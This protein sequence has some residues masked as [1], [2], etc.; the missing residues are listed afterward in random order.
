MLSKIISQIGKPCYTDKITADLEQGEGEGRLSYAR[1]LVEVNAHDKLKDQ[2]ILRG[3]DGSETIQK[4]WYEWRPWQCLKCKS[5]GHKEAEC[6][7]SSQK[8]VVRK[9]LP[10]S[11]PSHVN[12]SDHSKAA[13]HPNQTSNAESSKNDGQMIE[14]IQVSKALSTTTLTTSA[15]NIITQQLDVQSTAEIKEGNWVI[16]E[17][18]ILRE[19][20]T[21]WQKVS[22][23]KH[24]KEHT[25]EEDMDTSVMLKQAADVLQVISRLARGGSIII[26]HPNHP[27]A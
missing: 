4:I 1:I 6:E 15:P 26:D 10:K 13:N 14:P 3:P 27:H 17:Q 23:K 11:Q 9:W 16:Q 2:I 18:N 7:G 22:H 12:K 24:R 21:G 19:N 20:C 25:I 5:F 8:R